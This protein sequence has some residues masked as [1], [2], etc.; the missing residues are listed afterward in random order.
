ME[1]KA[2]PRKRAKRQD[3]TG[4][5]WYV[6]SENRWRAQFFDSSGS[7]RYLSGRSE[8]EIA[9]KLDRAI[10]ERDRGSLGLAPHET[11]SLGNWLDIWLESKYQLKPKTVL[12]YQT[13]IECFIKPALG[14]VR[15][16]QIKAPMIEALYGDLMKNQGLSP[17]SVKHVHATLSSALNTAYRHDVVPTQVMAKVSAPRITTTRRR[18]LDT[19]SVNS[20][21]ATA[22]RRGL[23][24][25]LRWR[26]AFLW[27]LRQGEA[28]GLRWQDIDLAEGRLFIRQQMQYF[29][30][31]GMV[32]GTLKSSSSSRSF[33]LDP[34]TIQDLRRYRKEQLAKR[35]S[36][37]HWVD[38]DLVFSTDEGRP[39]D[40]ASDRRQFK[41]ILTECGLHG[42]RVHDARH[43]AITNL[44]MDGVPL[45]T[46]KD[47]AGHSDIRVTSSYVHSTS[48]AF[49]DAAEKV[50]RRFG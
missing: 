25:Y 26:L 3:N 6:P 18:T 20:F 33:R 19:A 48:E 29:S 46:I 39:I 7:L 4:A 38:L 45:P 11:P 41:E 5:Y 37:P 1:H 2:Q 12:R 27:G 24:C 15:V 17:S 16:D 30:G 8:Q 10:A 40:T 9:S 36:V 47:I 44:A 13:D 21:L 35:M 23:A 22:E 43:T 32:A 28:L 34:K 31:Q 14:T 42:F 50:M 49:D